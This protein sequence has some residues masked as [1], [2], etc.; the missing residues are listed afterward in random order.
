MT[1]SIDEWVEDQLD[2]CD[3]SK[4]NYFDFV[5][6]FHFTNPTEAD[7]AYCRT[8]QAVSKSRVRDKQ[9]TQPIRTS[10]NKFKRRR[11]VAAQTSN[12]DVVSPQMQN[13]SNVIDKAMS[14]SVPSPAGSNTATDVDAASSQIQ[15]KL[16]VIGN[17]TS[18]SDYPQ[19]DPFTENHNL[20]DLQDTP[21]TDAALKSREELLKHLYPF[22]LVGS[23]EIIDL[24]LHDIKRSI[25]DEVL[26]AWGGKLKLPVWVPDLPCELFIANIINSSPNPHIL[27][28]KARQRE[29]VLSADLFDIFIHHDLRALEI[30]TEASLDM[31]QAPTHIMDHQVGERT[32]AVEFTIPFINALFRWFNDIVELKWLEVETESLKR[33]KWDGLGLAKNKNQEVASFLLELSGGTSANDEKVQSD[34]VKHPIRTFCCQY[35]NKVLYFESLTLV[36]NQKY[37][38]QRHVQIKVPQNGQ[39]LKDLLQKMHLVFGWRDAVVQ[40]ARNVKNARPLE[41]D[42]LH[43]EIFFDTKSPPSTQ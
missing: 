38:R 14:E 13:D 15:G 30:I 12:E 24:T 41:Q 6:R 25:N 1:T 42:S 20:V 2:D 21:L 8:L 5:E 43:G 23:L 18:T 17:P 35:H 22:D 40:L 26:S 39:E 4:F 10:L 7:L 11:N 34:E 29:P 28:V 32:L 36:D 33:H 19:A 16:S 9:I 37:I 27:R 3:E 31:L